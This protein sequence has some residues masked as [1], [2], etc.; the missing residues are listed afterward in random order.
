MEEGKACQKYFLE[1]KL[2]WVNNLNKSVDKCLSSIY[3]K[4]KI[5]VKK[6]IIYI[7]TKSLRSDPNH[8]LKINDIINMIN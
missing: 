2:D 5:L 3:C 7:F 6:E 1:N 4:D 8:R